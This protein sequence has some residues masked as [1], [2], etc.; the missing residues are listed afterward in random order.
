MSNINVIPYY[1]GEEVQLQVLQP[2]FSIYIPRVPRGITQEIISYYFWQNSFG[3]VKRVD[4][5]PI[6]KPPGFGE[7]QESE[8]YCAFVHFH[9]YCN[10]QYT[11]PIL[12]VLANEGGSY[13][14]YYDSSSSNYWILVKNHCPIPDSEMNTHQIVENSRIVERRVFEQNEHVQFLEDKI[15]G[16]EDKVY[17]L[18][19]SV[20]ILKAKVKEMEELIHKQADTIA[21]TQE[22][23]Y[24]LLGEG[25]R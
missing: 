2:K 5:A 15:Y 21:Q 13:R 17:N 6:G 23:I 16:L 3:S 12:D 11:Q 20:Y 10:N 8:F 14:Y 18:E 1:T 4:F 7:H 9:Y 24:K 25:V 19:D 22:I